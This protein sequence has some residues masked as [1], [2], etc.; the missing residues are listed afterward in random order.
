MRSAVL[1]VA[2]TFGCAQEIEVP[3]DAAAHSDAMS[4]DSGAAD[5]AALGTVGAAC[6]RNLDCEGGLACLLEA[7]GGY[8]SGPCNVTS[9]CTTGGVCD[10]VLG[11]GTC[12]R[13]CARAADCPRPG[14]VCARTFG[15]VMACIGPDDEDAG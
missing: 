11:F 10:V 15:G 14:Y 5:A 8:C 12:L 6:A 2:L 7:P 4:M 9:D 1:L 3:L 13:G